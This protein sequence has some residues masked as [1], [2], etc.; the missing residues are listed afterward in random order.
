MLLLLGQIAGCTPEVPLRH[1]FQYQ[2][3][4]VFLER[5]QQLH[6]IRALHRDAAVPDQPVLF[7]VLHGPL[8][9]FHLPEFLPGQ[10]KHL[11]GAFFL[12]V[13]LFQLGDAAAVIAAFLFLADPCLQQI[14]TALY[15]QILHLR[16]FPPQGQV[17]Y[18][19]F[20]SCRYVQVQLAVF[21]CGSLQQRGLPG[22]HKACRAILVAE[23]LPLPPPAE[24]GDCPAHVLLIPHQPHDLPFLYHPG[25]ERPDFKAC[26]S[27]LAD[28]PPD[29]PIQQ[30]QP[31]PLALHGDSGQL[32]H[33]HVVHQL[34]AIGTDISD[35][36]SFGWF[37]AEGAYGFLAADH[38]LVPHR[39]KP[40]E[41]GGGV[42][43]MA[44]ARPD[45]IRIEALP[46]CR[47]GN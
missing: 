30:R 43:R 39:V 46:T 33:P 18:Q 21:R 23:T 6:I 1:L 9:P 35:V 27:L 3:A 8:A 25:G 2:I 13:D 37:P 34:P 40:A 7:Q 16:T 12:P 14:A 20:P 32:C 10:P 26:C 22:D 44:S 41:G 45:L 4:I 29:A 31:V 19:P 36:D 42:G 28:A 15:H 11:G 24:Q 5:F 38:G 47:T 17:A